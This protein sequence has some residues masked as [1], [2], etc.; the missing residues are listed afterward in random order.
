VATAFTRLSSHHGRIPAAAALSRRVRCPVLW[1]EMPERVRGGVVERVGAC[2]VEAESQEGGFS[3][4]VAARLLL[5]DGRR[6]FVKAVGPR[7]NLEAP[8][9]HRRESM[10][11]VRDPLVSMLDIEV[12][13]VPE[14]RPHANPLDQ[15]PPNDHPAATPRLDPVVPPTRRCRRSSRACRNRCMCDRVR[16]R[17]AAVISRSGP[18]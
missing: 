12:I 13:G 9:V 5:D 8:S 10:V 7:P 11:A 16:P 3:P 2:V 14:R 4:G 17:C 6:V 15:P 18:V 1:Q